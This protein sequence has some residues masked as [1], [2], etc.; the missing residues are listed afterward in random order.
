[1][2]RSGLLLGALALAFA[3]VAFVAPPLRVST[4]R[5]LPD[6]VVR[7]EPPS[8]AGTVVMGV[9]AGLMVGLAVPASSWAVNDLPEFSVVRPSFM[10]GIDASLAAT[11]PGE[12]DFVT[13]SRIEASYFPQVIEE[14]KQEKVKLEAAPSKKERLEKAAQQMRE[15]AKT[16]QIGDATAP[17]GGGRG[18]DGVLSLYLKENANKIEDVQVRIF[19]VYGRISTQTGHMKRNTGSGVWGYKLKEKVAEYLGTAEAFMEDHG[20]VD[21]EEEWYE[22]E[23][24]EEEHEH[25]HG[26]LDMQKLQD[27]L[28]DDAYTYSV[29]AESPASMAG[30]VA[31]H[32]QVKELLTVIEDIR[33]EEDQFKAGGVPIAHIRG[34][35]NN[36]K[37]SR[38]TLFVL[39]NIHYKSGKI[40]PIS[41]VDLA[42]SEDPAVMVGGFLRFVNRPGVPECDPANGKTPAQLMAKYLANLSSYEQM[43]SSLAWCF[44]LKDVLVECDRTKPEKGCVDV[45]LAGGRSEFLRP[46]LDK[47]ELWRS[48]DF[49]G[50]NLPAGLTFIWT[51]TKTKRNKTVFYHFD[52]IFEMQ[53]LGPPNGLTEKRKQTNP[54]G[55]DWYWAERLWGRCLKA[56][57][58]NCKKDSPGVVD[59]IVLGDKHL[60][61]NSYTKLGNNPS[62][63]TEV[64]GK[65]TVIQRNS[66]DFGDWKKNG[67]KS[68]KPGEETEQVAEWKSQRKWFFEALADVMSRLNNDE[69]DRHLRYFTSA[70]G[71]VVEEAFFINEVQACHP[72]CFPVAE[73]VLDS[74]S[75]H[76]LLI[77]VLTSWMPQDVAGACDADAVMA[78]ATCMQQLSMPTDGNVDTTCQY[79]QDYMACYPG[80]CCTSAVETALATFGQAPFNCAG[81]TCGSNSNTG[82]SNTGG[83][84][85][86][87]SNTGDSGC[88]ADAVMAA[89]TCMQQLSMPTDG[90]VDTTC[91]YVQ[92]YMA[93]YPGDCCTSAVETALATFGQ[94][95]FNCAG[96]TCGSNSNTGNSNTGGSNTGGSNTGD[97]GCT[98]DAVMAAATCMQQLSMPT[99]GNVD[100]T[101]QY[102][103]DYMACYPGAC[104]TSAVETALATFGQAPFNCAGTTCGSGSPA[105]STTTPFVV[106][107]G[108]VSQTSQCSGTFVAGANVGWTGEETTQQSVMSWEACCS[109]CN[110]DVCC[111]YVLISDGVCFQKIGST[112]ELI[113]PPESTSD[114]ASISLLSLATMQVALR[115]AF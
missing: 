61:S 105:A 32:E 110:P 67:Q 86:G 53:R 58:G 106:G 95:P 66:K 15:Y 23:E 34:T 17:V 45:E 62:P 39:T 68:S 84:N 16:A 107:A 64:P 5:S 81:T 73:A 97:S 77:M 57:S 102:V 85:T 74:M 101:C 37:S 26:R 20:E 36:P 13:R 24:E 93:C 113:A 54:L 8:D 59:Y 31:W 12:I 2:T 69:F 109:L 90:N 63:L 88:T 60:S 104:C 28:D 49:A 89:A 75:R 35:V 7:P 43:S 1:M 83:S 70:I 80:D 92:D 11:K 52:E 38:G 115:V 78:A 29:K 87:G 42:G 4:P 94:A 111:G 9:L 65:L 98:A 76:L 51:D 14:L 18:I 96:T 27:A 56:K 41:T 25:R 46:K 47:P 40:A 71:P 19:E 10:Q 114:A 72:T 30:T 55:P 108:L 44:E 6:K 79:V 100:T 82:N 91:Q 99:D 112:C 3:T 22:D 21:E 50:E 33:M 48:K 103:Q